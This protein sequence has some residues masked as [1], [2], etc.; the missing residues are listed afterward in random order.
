MGITV[1]Q[2]IRQAEEKRRAEDDLREPASGG[3]APGGGLLQSH[4]RRA[5]PPV[6]QRCGRDDGA[7]RYDPRD[8]ADARFL[9]TFT[10][11]P[12]VDAHAASEVLLCISC[13]DR[14]A[15]D[16]IADQALAAGGREAREAQDMGFMYSRSFEDPDGHI[17]EPMF[18]DMAAASE[19]MAQPQPQPV[20]A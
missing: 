7:F 13:D 5:E 4:R 2:A 16:Q 1:K 3:P 19:A 10:P 15:V 17:W 14:A 9:R 8:V 6:Q 20:E 18:M 12:I 11:K